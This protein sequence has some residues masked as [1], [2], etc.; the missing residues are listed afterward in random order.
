MILT[1]ILLLVIALLILVRIAQAGSWR[2]YLG[3][4]IQQTKLKRVNRV[5]DNEP[6]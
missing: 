6:K 2:Y 5:R 3:K 4:R 1:D